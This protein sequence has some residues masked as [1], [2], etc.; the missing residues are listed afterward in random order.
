MP[1]L[2]G[3][4]ASFAPGTC[5]SEDT[6]VSNEVSGLT[7]VDRTDNMSAVDHQWQITESRAS[8]LPTENPVQEGTTRHLSHTGTLSHTLMRMPDVLKATGLSRSTLYSLARQG[9]FPAPIHLTS[10]AI[11]WDSRLIAEWI[12]RRVAASAT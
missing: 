1:S 6:K 12:E 2:A 10:R 7:R 3:Q 5:T 8:P 4:L 11:A 9:D